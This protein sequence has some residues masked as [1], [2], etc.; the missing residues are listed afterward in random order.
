[1]S[2]FLQTLK[3]YLAT[4]ETPAPATPDAEPGVVVMIEGEPM[5]IEQVLSN[6]WEWGEKLGLGFPGG[7]E[8]SPPGPHLDKGLLK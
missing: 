8:R 4:D 6:D 7:D 5:S 2:F 3:N 1:M